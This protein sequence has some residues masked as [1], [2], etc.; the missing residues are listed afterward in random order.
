MFSPLRDIQKGRGELW[1]DARLS[2]ERELHPLYIE[3]GFTPP[4][5]SFRLGYRLAQGGRI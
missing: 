4:S 5:E 1:V 2:R 3:S